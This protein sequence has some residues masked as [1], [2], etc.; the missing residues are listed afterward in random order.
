MALPAAAIDLLRVQHGLIT[1]R[2]ALAAGCTPR[3]IERLVGNG[4]F[5][6]AHA[7]LYRAA[8]ST[9]TR[10]QALLFP[11][12]ATGDGVLSH[13]TAAELAGGRLPDYDRTELVE[14]TVR[15]ERLWH[16]PG[17]MFHRSRDLTA[18]Q[19][20]RIDGLPVTTP[21][22]TL[23]DLGQVV[24]WTTVRSTF[25]QFR[26]AGLVT[27]ES[28]RAALALHSRKG[29]RGC[30]ALRRVIDEWGPVDAP[31]ESVLE[32][33]LLRLCRDHDLPLPTAQ[34]EVR[35]GGRTRR[36]D[37]AYPDLRLAIEVDG[38]ATHA[39]TERFEDDRARR[40]ELMLAGWTVLHFTWTMV[41]HDPAG[42]ARQIRAAL[43]GATR[44]A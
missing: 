44:T 41:V 24:G 38:Y 12:L 25:D 13:R 17:T 16:L 7:G 8:A 42:V 20:T 3:Q 39:T 40:N 29:R 34:V 36:L 19:I 33:A 21:T 18:A 2:Q 5:E 6:V 1:R 37:F 15:R 28:T 11:C 10:Q 30:G 23:V 43:A 35:V 32:A 22:R 26:I 9:V 31:V 27:F 14:L 4:T